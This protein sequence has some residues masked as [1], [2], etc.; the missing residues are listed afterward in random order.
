MSNEKTIPGLKTTIYQP[1]HVTNARYHFTL[2]QERI[3]TYLIF[4]LQNYI[5]RVKSGEEVEQLELFSSGEQTI[6]VKVPMDFICPDQPAMYPKIRSSVKSMASLP[7]SI[8]YIGKDGRDWIEYTN[9]FSVHITA[10]NQRSKYI[11]LGVRKD[12]AKILVDINFKNGKPINFTSFVF[13]YAMK[14]KCKYTPRIY[15]FLCSWKSKGITY[16]ISLQEFKEMIG[17]KGKYPSFPDFKKSV[18]IPVNEELKILA[19]CWLDLDYD[20]FE[21]VV[22][23]KVEKLSFKIITADVVEAIAKQWDYVYYLLKT[24]LQISNKQCDQ[25]QQIFRD[26]DTKPDL[27]LQK[28]MELN[29]RIK[30]GEGEIKHIPAYVIKALLDEFSEKV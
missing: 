3:F 29:H 9:A 7:I 17:A 18:L 28:I 2:I 5:N 15:K 10:D 24:H 22:N 26:N 21:N 6:K 14:A 20:N 25:L 16:P 1:N 30:T 19:D 23:G 8:P 27:V 4:N 13:E 11:I 12:I